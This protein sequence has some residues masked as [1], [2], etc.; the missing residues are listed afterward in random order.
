MTA[1]LIYSGSLDY[2]FHFDDYQNIIDNTKIHDLSD[3]DAWWNYSANRPVSMFSLVLNYHFHELDV[4]YYRL[5]NILIHIINALIIW[6]L[7][8]LIFSS[9][10]LKHTAIARHKRAIGFFTA[11]LFVSH[12]LA[13]QSV[14]YIVQRHTSMAAMFYLLSVSMYMKARLP[15]KAGKLRYLLFFGVLVC[16]IL[17]MLSKENAYTLP[18]ALLLVEVCFLQT[19]RI[20]F[21]LKNY[22]IILLITGF[23][24]IVLFLLYKFSLDIFDPIPE[25]HCLGTAGTITPINYLLTQFRVIVIYI[26][27][28]ILPV[29]QN[30]DYDIALSHSFFELGTLLSFLFLTFLFLFS[31]YIYNRNRV[32]SFGILWFFITL[33]VESSFIPIADVIFEHRTYLPS[34]GFFLIISTGLHMLFRDKIARAAAVLMLLALAWAVMA[35]ERNKVWESEFTLWNDVISKSPDKARPFVNR[36][37]HYRNNQQWYKAIDDYTRAIEISS[38][39][40]I[41]FF[42]RGVAYINTEQWYK[43]IDDFTGIEN[44]SSEYPI[45]YYYRGIAYSRTGQLE[46][47]I[48]DYDRFVR[49]RSEFDLAYIN[50]GTTYFDLGDYEKAIAD[51][52]RAIELSPGSV[53]ARLNLSKAYFRQGAW[54]KAVEESANTIALDPNN[55]SAFFVRG[56]ALHNLGKP[57]QAIENY[58]KAI[59][60]DPGYF[61]A[62]LYRGDGYMQ[63]GQWSKALADYN[64]AVQINPDH[65]KA[66]ARRKM[67]L[68]RVSQ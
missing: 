58:S 16:G 59:D 42:R 9:P 1:V 56:G 19:K 57:E 50:R 13:T 65:H 23:L 37:S 51:Y 27:L 68:Q 34:F 44:F 6:W 8:F 7:T 64:M 22:R 61:S 33:S 18:F 15:G 26:Q 3:V 14:T 2:S 48:Y 30:L 49:V 36:G 66:Q 45:I 24:G 38:K 41:I 62:Y 11:L 20:H 5:V 52:I 12:P 43:A 53:K 60:S 63:L 29:N 35:H 4:R 10:V 47:A 67:A 17:G 32:I 46:K 25:T 39:Y 54:E 31:I 40:P 21:S 55:A 28:L